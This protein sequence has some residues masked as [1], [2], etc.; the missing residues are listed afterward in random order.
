MPDNFE[1]I[2]LR[3]TV[4]GGQS[5]ADDYAVVWRGC[6]LAGSCERPA[7]RLTSRNGVGP[8][9]SMASPVATVDQ[10]SIWTTARRNSRKHG[11]TIRGG[12]TDE[13]IA[14]AHRYAEASAEALARYDRKRGT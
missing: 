4:I 11:R 7:C 6:P 8:A 9:T 1:T 10:A 5:Y 13:D 14:R 3:A 12:L 2:A